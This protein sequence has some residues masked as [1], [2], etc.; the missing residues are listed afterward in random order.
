[1]KYLKIITKL[2]L[3]FSLL[4]SNLYAQY[5][6]GTAIYSEAFD[7]NAPPTSYPKIPNVSNNYTL[8]KILMVISMLMLLW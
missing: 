5:D 6:G 1:M 2:L 4:C 3:G 8:L 7:T